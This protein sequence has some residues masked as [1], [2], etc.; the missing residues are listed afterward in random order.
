MMSDDCPIFLFGLEFEVR[1]EI[2]GVVRDGI[3]LVVDGSGGDDSTDARVDAVL[4]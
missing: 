2:L 3:L 1:N 4:I